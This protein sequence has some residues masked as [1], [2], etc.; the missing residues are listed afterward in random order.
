MNFLM[1][2]LK[3]LAHPLMMPVYFLLVLFISFGYFSVN[4]SIL[5]YLL[6]FVFITISLLPGL[7]LYMAGRTGL[8]SRPLDPKG[9][10]K[11]IA[12]LLL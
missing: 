8:I 11:R 7:S 1:Q 5:L 10:D 3:I 6:L 2:F 12:F 9:K 4:P